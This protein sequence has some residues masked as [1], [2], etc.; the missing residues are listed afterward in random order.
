MQ[1]AFRLVVTTQVCE[2]YGAHCWDGTGDCP[3][4]WK[5]K[6]GNEVVVAKGNPQ[7]VSRAWKRLN[8]NNPRFSHKSEYWEEYPINVQILA[9]GEETEDEKLKREWE[10]AF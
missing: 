7:R 2:N 4:G 1:N 6:G 3:Q 8:L 9:P 10:G 5:F